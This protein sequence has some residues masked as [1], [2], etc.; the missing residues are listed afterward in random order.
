MADDEEAID[1]DEDEKLEGFRKL[2]VSFIS[3]LGG[4]TYGQ[5]YKVSYNGS[6]MAIKIMKN[7]EYAEIDVS[8]SID[9]PYILY[10]HMIFLPTVAHTQDMG[11][12]LPLAESTAAEY[13]N[14]TYTFSERLSFFRKILEGLACL[15]AN[16]ILHLD[17]KP[18]NIL[19][20]LIKREYHDSVT[21]T[22][23]KVNVREPLI[24]DFGLSLRTISI[25]DGTFSKGSKGTVSHRPPENFMEHYPADMHE[26]EKINRR[27]SINYSFDMWSVGV[28]GFTLLLKSRFFPEAVRNNGYKTEE[29]YLYLLDKFGSF[30]RAKNFITQAVSESRW[31]P[32]DKAD[33][34]IR[35]LLRMIQ[36]NRESREQSIVVLTDP[37]FNDIVTPVTVCSNRRVEVVIPQDLKSPEDLKTQ[38]ITHI[39]GIMSI[40]WV[41]TGLNRMDMTAFFH[42]YDLLYRYFAI[43]DIEM[44]PTPK[45]YYS[46][47]L[48][49]IWGSIRSRN[50]NIPPSSLLTAFHKAF[51]GLAPED[52]IRD[53]KDFV[54]HMDRLIHLSSGIVYRRHI[55]EETTTKIEVGHA[56]TTY[57]L[58][59]VSYYNHVP[60]VVD[61]QEPLIFKEEGV[62][63]LT[64]AALFD[65]K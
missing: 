54:V 36:F 6:L 7:Y 30:E 12:L 5:V 44:T 23:R 60:R 16:G 18:A 21:N 59:P 25:I 55:Y 14:G 4:G 47:A 11:V 45:F 39:S 15:H 52:D 20:Q 51:P 13:I 1:L 57:F 2:G 53:F 37:I 24:S 32:K 63:R 64:V 17:I 9:N 28:I 31:V 26:D 49:M 29:V 27:G 65:K 61:P 35:L 43:K 48:G 42:S 58:H 41:N 3:R 62:E 46:V 34:V 19:V 10:N 56:Y 33:D 38:M 50:Y 22:D 40:L 8:S